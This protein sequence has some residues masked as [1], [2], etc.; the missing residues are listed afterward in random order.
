MKGQGDRVM[1]IYTAVIA[2]VSI[3]EVR[4]MKKEG[5]KKEIALFFPLA[6]AALVLAWIYTSRPEASISA[7]FLKAFGIP[8]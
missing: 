8:F 3:L 5:L 6:V 1:L 7:F 2:V 4:Q